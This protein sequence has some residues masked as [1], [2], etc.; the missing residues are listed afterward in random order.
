VC[1]RFDERLLDRPLEVFFLE[2]LLSSHHRTAIAEEA[3]LFMVPVSSRLVDQ[4]NRN[5]GQRTLAAVDYIR[6]TWPYFDC[7]QG[8]KQIVS[9]QS[10][11]S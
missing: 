4:I 8:N 1:F 7:N 10:L 9:L 6:N 3:D 11:V 2:R 5:S